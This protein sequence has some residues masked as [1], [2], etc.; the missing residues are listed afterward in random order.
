[1]NKRCDWIKEPQ[2]LL[3]LFVLS[4]LAFL[5]VDIFIAHSVNAFARPAEWVPVIFSIVSPVVLVLIYAI[6][7]S[8]R[9]ADH[10]V[11]KG[12][13]LL[14]GWC[15]IIVGI[16]GMLLHLNSQFFRQQS[17]KHLVYTAP[18]IAPL[19]YAGL[20]F[21]LLLNRMIPRPRANWALWVIFFA[22]GG[23][24]GN[25]GLSLADHAQNGFYDWREW[26]AVWAAAIAVGFLV[27][28]LL[29]KVGSY[30]LKL[31][32][33]IMLVQMLVGVV[34]FVF[35][36]MTDLHGQM[37]SMWENL[38]Y[39]T[40]IFAPLLYVNLA[41]LALLGLWALNHASTEA[42]DSQDE[43]IHAVTQSV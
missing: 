4:N 27:V 28:P 32:G 36:G 25:F 30:Y 10:G 11:A 16:A 35:H 40:P 18:F 7:R 42:K 19:S 31:T 26:I 9:P 13:G 22:L 43:P 1:M 41:L 33:L 12:L 20:G 15:A 23:F 34:G 37:G 2:I 38:L 8:V 21:L 6:Q 3:E 39:G 5:A 14:V 17:L 29:M 24:V